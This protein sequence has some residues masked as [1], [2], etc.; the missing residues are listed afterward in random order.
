MKLCMFKLKLANQPTPY[1]TV[2]QTRLK[3]CII[4]FCTYIKKIQ[5]LNIDHALC[6]LQSFVLLQAIIFFNNKS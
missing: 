4:V 1:S 6:N 3:T 5:Q 2:V